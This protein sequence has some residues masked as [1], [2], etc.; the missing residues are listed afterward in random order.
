MSV[1]ADAK[2]LNTQSRRALMQ[3]LRALIYSLLNEWDKTH[4]LYEPLFAEIDKSL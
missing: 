3:M 4:V 2:S 1:D